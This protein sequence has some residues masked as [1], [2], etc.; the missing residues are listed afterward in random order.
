MQKTAHKFEGRAFGRLLVVKRLENHITSG[1]NTLSKW[2]CRCVCGNEI[3]VIGNDLRSEKTKSCGCLHKESSRT[4]GRANRTHGGYSDLCSADDRV[5]FMAIRQIK[6]RAN[7]RGYESD[8]D[9]SDLPILTDTCPVLGIKYKKGKGKLQDASPT[10]DRFNSNL[11]YL[12][13]YKD[14][15]TFMSHKANRIKNNGTAEDLRKILLFIES[16]VSH[17]EESENLL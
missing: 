10:I 3:S 7:R 8:L 16:R 13:K 6:V 1:G 15:L 4:N 11:P 17:S 14:N 2:L 12:R 9:I 5:K